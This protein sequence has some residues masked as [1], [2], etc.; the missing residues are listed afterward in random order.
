[1]SGFLARAGLPAGLLSAGLA[2]GLWSWS[3]QRSSQLQDLEIASDDHWIDAGFVEMVSPISPPTSRDESDL[4]EVWLRLPAGR[5][6]D[7]TTAD[8][9]RPLL[10]LPPGTL[11][12]RVERIASM[13]GSR[14]VDVRGTELLQDGGQQFH[15][16]RRVGQSMRGFSWARGSADGQREADARV[17]ELVPA[18]AVAKLRRLNDCASCHLEKKSEQREVDG[19]GLPNRRTDDVGFYQVQAVLDDEQPLETTRPRDT[20]VDEPF[21]V[22]SCPNGSPAQQGGFDDG[23]RTVRCE[24]NGLPR[25]RYDVAAGLGAGALRALRVC[26]SRR[27]LYE[28]MTDRARAAFRAEFAACGLAETTELEAGSV[29]ASDVERKE[30]ASWTRR[31][32][33]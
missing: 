19:S 4:I 10:A 11:A 18:S 20:N 27:Y 21:V 26:A 29:P 1:M 7:V 31:A 17:A 30:T 13:T 23:R 25:A 32:L 3:S 15:M 14:V 2:L 24:G 22:L 12:D 28:H 6:V 33:K 5:T 16:L 8:G 9:A